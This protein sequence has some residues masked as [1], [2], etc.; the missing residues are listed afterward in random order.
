MIITH[1]DLS[2]GASFDPHS[3]GSCLENEF[4]FVNEKQVDFTRL[5]PLLV[6]VEVSFPF[7]APE[8]RFGFD[9]RDPQAC[10]PGP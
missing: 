4:D 8:K 10:L 5:C 7:F 2:Q 9:D 6:V 1:W 3:R